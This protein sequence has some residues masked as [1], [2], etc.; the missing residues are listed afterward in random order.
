MA[1]TFIGPA[2]PSSGFSTIIGKNTATSALR[3]L[4]NR[5][6]SERNMAQHRLS[7]A[8]KLLAAFISSALVRY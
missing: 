6:I 7:A 3:L 5:V 2:G 1:G 4:R 8:G